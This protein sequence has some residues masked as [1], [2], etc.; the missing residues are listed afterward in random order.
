MVNLLVVKQNG[1]TWWLIF[2]GCVA[3][4]LAAMVGVTVVVLKLEQ[5]NRRAR[6]ES[7]RQD[8]L[9]LALWRMD[10]WLAARLAREAAR[11]YFEYFA[12]Y[13]PESV[14]TRLLNEIR[15]GD[16]LSPS[17]LLTF[18]SQY[19]PIHFQIDDRGVF[20]SPQVPT[21]NQLDLAEANFL[22][23]GRVHEMAR[24]LD[25]VRRLIGTRDVAALCSGAQQI[26]S[27]QLD[28]ENLSQPQEDQIAQRAEKGGQFDRNWAELQKRAEHTYQSQQVLAELPIGKRD[29]PDNPA[30]LVSIGPLVPVWLDDPEPDMIDPG[31]DDRPSL[32]FL[33]RVNAG[34]REF[35]QG[36]LGH[37]PALRASLVAQASDLVPGLG[38][39]PSRV[40][41]PTREASVWML[42]TIP[43]VVEAPPPPETPSAISTA[44]VT[45]VLMWLGVLIAIA[46]TGLTLRSTIDFAN[47]RQRFASAVTH[48]LR[49]P[50]TTFQMYSE[51]LAEGMVSDPARQ[52][53]YHETLRDESTR[54]SALVENVL[55][56]SRIED[57]R[58]KPH[59]E[60]MTPRA[61]FDHLLP[62]IERRA[63]KSDASLVVSVDD[64]SDESFDLDRET[65]GRIVFNLVDN[66]CKY[67][68]DHD[69]PRIEL[70]ADA[71][72]DRL[73]ITVR[74]HGRGVPERLTGRIF[75]PF[76]RGNVEPGSQT[77]GV[78]L[79]LSLSRELAATLGG[80]LRLCPVSDG[81]GACFRLV[82]PLQRA[83]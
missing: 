31:D 26:A 40:P 70:T 29:Q 9:H 38:I 19:F 44:R 32:I 65:I 36:F 53:V 64:L 28:S 11:P 6:A 13:A 47:R 16:V 27:S 49:T 45:L 25:E 66:A 78:G 67:G 81:P 83:V 5:D 76:D 37:W 60:P 18:E 58:A 46:A 34:T 80:T 10:S 77:P 74:D 14:Y 30:S 42:T 73:T 15:P 21:G 33:R 7:D 56:Y 51:L 3:V 63:K 48:E 52:K 59:R 1:Q 69:A 22:P 72:N 71:H 43:A 4:V 41:A 54:L 39:E 17:P 62:E 24:R 20:S 23:D 79:G 75:Q 82:V 35:Y 57:G 68:C 50:L 61:L 8:T 12:Y 2:G 55:A